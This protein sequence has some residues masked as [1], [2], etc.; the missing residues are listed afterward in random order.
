MADP[1]R[2]PEQRVRDTLALF[3]AEVDAWFATTDGA[4]P[5]LVPL[6][7]AWHDGV[8]LAATEA[9]SRT[10]RNLTAHPD[11]RIALGGTR[12]VV[13]VEGRAAVL[14]LDAL[15]AAALAQLTAKLDSDPRQWADA[16]IL[17]RPDRIQAWREENELAGR[18]LMRHGS[19]VAGTGDSP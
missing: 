10:V 13:I 15:G 8:L 19:W 18:V 5:W 16:A 14:A 17:V 2:P 9:R 1:A 7:F 3:E 6:T 4:R 12:D 11:V